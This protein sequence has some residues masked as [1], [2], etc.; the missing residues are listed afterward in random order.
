VDPNM[1]YKR[2]PFLLLGAACGLSD[3][4]RIEW[5]VPIA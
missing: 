3:A 1:M 2:D 4:C 5:G